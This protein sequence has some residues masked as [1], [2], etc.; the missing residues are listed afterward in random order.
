[1]A[2]LN[3]SKLRRSRMSR[4]PLAPALVV[5]ESTTDETIE[6]VSSDPRR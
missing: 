1:M 2:L 4:L 5:A 3:R 6:R